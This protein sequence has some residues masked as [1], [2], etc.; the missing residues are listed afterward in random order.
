MPPHL[1]GGMTLCK[2]QS[3]N[4]DNSKILLIKVLF[5]QARMKENQPTI[6]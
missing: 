1:L 2:Y 6:A 3:E 5:F 4:G